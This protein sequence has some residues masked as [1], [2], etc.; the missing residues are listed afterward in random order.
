MLKLADEPAASELVALVGVEDFSRAVAGDGLFHG[1]DTEARRQTVGES[2]GL[3]Y[4]RN[5][6][7]HQPVTTKSDQCTSA[8]DLALLATF[9][10]APSISATCQ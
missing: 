10:K 3:P 7:F 5:R 6:F 8:G 2:A 4:L 1:L 9:C